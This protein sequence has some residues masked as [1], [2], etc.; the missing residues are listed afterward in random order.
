MAFD[1]GAGQKAAAQ[2][3]FDVIEYA[4]RTF[5]AAP[6]DA[7]S[8]D[9]CTYCE[10]VKKDVKRYKKSGYGTVWDPMVVKGI[11][12]PPKA[13]DKEYHRATVIARVQRIEIVDSSGTVVDS[14]KPGMELEYSFALHW[15]GV[16][17]LGEVGISEIVR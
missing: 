7:F 1:D 6:L 3:A 9:G 12:A 11:T 8:M 16:W 5:D 13:P 15:D 4:L 10:S 2:Y 17:R 14:E